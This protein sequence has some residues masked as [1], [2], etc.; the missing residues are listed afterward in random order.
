M[1]DTNAHITNGMAVLRRPSLRE[2]LVRRLGESEARA[3]ADEPAGVACAAQAREEVNALEPHFRDPGATP[4]RWV[5][6]V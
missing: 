5:R 2:W 1:F 6:L 4:A 3:C